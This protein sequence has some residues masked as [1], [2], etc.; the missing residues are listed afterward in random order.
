[1]TSQES[2]W[3]V[4]DNRR[5]EKFFEELEEKFSKELST[6]SDF[7]RVVAEYP[8]RFA[9]LVNKL[10]EGYRPGFLADLI[11]SCNCLCLSYWRDYVKS[12]WESSNPESLLSQFDQLPRI[13][14]FLAALGLDHSIVGKY[15]TLA[16]EEL[17]ARHA[18]ADG[19]RGEDYYEQ[20]G[21]KF[22][23]P[24]ANLVI[25]PQTESQ[26]VR[27]FIGRPSTIFGSGGS[28]FFSDDESTRGAMK[29]FPLCQRVSIGRQRSK[30]PGAFNMV[31]GKQRH[32]LVIAD[33]TDV[34]VASREQLL[35]A[36][37]TP[38]VLYMKNM[39]EHFP[40]ETSSFRGFKSLSPGESTL[41]L[42]DI[43]IRINK[44]RI[45]VLPAEHVC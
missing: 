30:E 13:T 23:V 31:Y 11:C 37:L 19:G 39:S 3:S 6:K 43:T 27:D 33:E 18:Y 21:C 5:E 44:V 32:R 25:V 2:E 12:Q 42:S 40:I 15:P 8:R 10:P 24:E 35:I 26:I 20:F 34:Q 38:Q 16:K 41:V 22:Q 9:E 14:S 1:M 7:P 28:S 17:V 36:R 29:R 45:E 4:W